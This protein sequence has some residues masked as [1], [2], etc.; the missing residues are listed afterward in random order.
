[1]TYM[2]ASQAANKW[3]VSQRRVQILCSQNRINGV[4]KLGENWA[5][6]DNAEK[7]S[8]QR[9]KAGGQDETV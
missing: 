2:T 5:I 7:P 8:D 1:M 3:N 4:F 9:R 6:P